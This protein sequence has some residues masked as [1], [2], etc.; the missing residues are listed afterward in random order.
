[1]K[2]KLSKE[3][4]SKLLD[5]LAA[6]HSHSDPSQ[7]AICKSCQDRW[8]VYQKEKARLTELEKNN[9]GKDLLDQGVEIYFK[10]L[11]IPDWRAK[12][13]EHLK[14]K[15][16]SLAQEVENIKRYLKNKGININQYN[17]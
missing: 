14:S 5:M 2:K 16:L 17:V 8:V 6:P 3:S 1:M 4:R 13:E 15:G 11:S 9:L 7:W 10:L 12:R